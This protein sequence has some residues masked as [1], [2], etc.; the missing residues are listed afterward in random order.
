MEFD[1]SILILKYHILQYHMI[2]HCRFLLYRHIIT[3][4]NVDDFSC[5]THVSSCLSNTTNNVND[6]SNRPF[7]QGDK[8]CKTC[9]LIKGS[10]CKAQQYRCI[11]QYTH[12]TVVQM[13]R[14]VVHRG[15]CFLLTAVLPFHRI[16][17]CGHI[18]Q[19]PHNDEI[20]Q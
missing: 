11:I 4:K 16:F 8:Y 17:K 12:G 2:G 18:F 1:I 15:C 3:L 14:H 7:I 10:D 20:I 6:T 9:I 5:T 13:S 19:H